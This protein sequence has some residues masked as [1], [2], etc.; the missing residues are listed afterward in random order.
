[1]R[2]PSAMPF[3]ER[4]AEVASTG[5]VRVQSEVGKGS[6]FEV[7]LPLLQRKFSIKVIHQ[8]N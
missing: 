7:R 4:I 1:M 8:I 5:E 2:A 3:L 6:T